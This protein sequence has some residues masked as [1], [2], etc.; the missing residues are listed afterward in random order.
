M[1]NARTYRIIERLATLNTRPFHER[2]FNSQE[3]SFASLPILYISYAKITC[4]INSWGPGMITTTLIRLQV[5]MQVL[6]SVLYGGWMEIS[7]LIEAWKCNFLAVLGHN[8]RLSDGP[9]KR[10]TYQQ[11]DMRVQREAKHPCPCWQDEI[12]ISM[13]TTRVSWRQAPDPDRPYHPQSHSKTKAVVKTM[14]WKEYTRSVWECVFDYLIFIFG[15]R[16]V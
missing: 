16:L 5:L 4:M 14:C 9:T 2:V 3:L 1:I 13:W 10:L 6:A 12:I 7:A 11:T 15:S 8:D